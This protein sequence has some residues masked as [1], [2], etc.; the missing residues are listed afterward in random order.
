MER[1]LRDFERYIRQVSLEEI[2]PA[3][4]ERISDLRIL[5]V[6]AGGLGA[7]AAVYLAAAGV[8]FLG[9]VDHDVVELGNLQRQ[10]LYRDQDLG[11][12]KADI[13]ARRL[14]EV[15][16]QVEVASFPV[17]LTASNAAEIFNGY[18]VVVGATDN[19]ESRLIIAGTCRDLSIPYVYGGINKFEVQVMSVMPG[20]SCCFGCI[21]GEAMDSEEPPSGPLGGVAGIGGTIQSV[22]AL[23]IGARFGEPLYNRLLVFD[24]LAMN[25]RVL[26]LT[27][28]S[29]CAICGGA[30]R[31]GI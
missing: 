15:Y 21:Y 6:G 24:A 30:G 20:E 9:V 7:P 27:R 26:S 25:V 8:G 17:K 22:E 11:G 10:I 19:F 23:K 4:Q 5:I 12:G 29:D 1:E 2:G 14:A 16:P 31:A 28:R 18:D 13:A 3:G